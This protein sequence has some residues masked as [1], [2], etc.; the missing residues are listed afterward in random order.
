[1]PE[2][3]NRIVTDHL[4]DYLLT[5]T[6]AA[7]DNLQKEGLH[8]MNVGDLMVDLI[9]GVAEPGKYVLATI[10]RASNTDTKEKLTEV[11]EYLKEFDM[12]V[13][14]PMHPRTKKMIEKFD[15]DMGDI[16]VIDP[17]GFK[18]ML[19]LESKAALIVTDSGGVQR[20]AY[21]LGVPFIIMR[22]TNE[23]SELQGGPTGLL[24][25]DTTVKTVLCIRN[26]LD[27]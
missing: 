2:E 26:I 4:S 16:E 7:N 25:E 3:M 27:V 21:I 5:P 20:E 9:Y 15:I 8:S 23:W 11:I 13:I 17:V 10:H 19:Q 1:M 24:G 6:Q 22:D 12:N 14:F 18:E